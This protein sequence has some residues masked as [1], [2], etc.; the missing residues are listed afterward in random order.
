MPLVFRRQ[1][2]QLFYGLAKWPR[3]LMSKEPLLR[4]LNYQQINLWAN[5]LLATE[6]YIFRRLQRWD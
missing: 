5:H 2:W 4:W 1:R 3:S 6:P